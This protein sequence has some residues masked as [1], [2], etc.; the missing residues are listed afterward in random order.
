MTFNPSN[1]DFII[2]FSK[3]L[4]AAYISRVTRAEIRLLDIDRDKPHM[5]FLAYNAHFNSLSFELLGSKVFRTE[6]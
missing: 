2:F 4:A 1:E 5:K 3:F 6:A